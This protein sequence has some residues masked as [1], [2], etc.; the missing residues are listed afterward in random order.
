M[1]V[2]DDIRPATDLEARVGELE[3]QV[4]VLTVALA[5]DIHVPGFRLATRKARAEC[6]Q[7]FADVRVL[8]DRWRQR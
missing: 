3:Q 8:A 4:R 7:V 6:K 1:T 2:P 5:Y